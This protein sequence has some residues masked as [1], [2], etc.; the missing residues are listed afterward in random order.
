MVPHFLLTEEGRGE[1]KSK[2]D[3]EKW[4]GFQGE[5]VPAHHWGLDAREDSEPGGDRQA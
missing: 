4:G 5:G 1:K 3:Q 2:G